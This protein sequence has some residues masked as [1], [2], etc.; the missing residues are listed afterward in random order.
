MIPAA[1]RAAWGAGTLLDC[2][3]QEYGWVLKHA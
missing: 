3:D 1:L 2:L